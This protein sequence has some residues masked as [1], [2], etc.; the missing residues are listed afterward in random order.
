M[1]MPTKTR[2]S[3]PFAGRS[4]VGILAAFLAVAALNLRGESW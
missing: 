3:A 1:V 2:N 4:L